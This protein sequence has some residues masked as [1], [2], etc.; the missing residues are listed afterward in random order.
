[1]DKIALQCDFLWSSIFHCINPMV[2]FLQTV[3]A[4]AY[5]VNMSLAVLI[6]FQRW[7][8]YETKLSK[9]LARSAYCVYPIHLLDLLGVTIAYIEFYKSVFGTGEEVEVGR[10]VGAWVFVNVSTQ[11]VVWPLSYGL[12]CLPVL[13]NII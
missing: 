11:V 6:I 12:T 7:F 8:N 9:T 4:G 10:V 1:M 2:I 5:C 3:T 13:C